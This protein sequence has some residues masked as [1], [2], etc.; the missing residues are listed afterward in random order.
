MLM[1]GFVQQVA[2]RKTKIG[3]M[4]DLVVNGDSYGH[5][6]YA[7]RGIS[8]GDYVEFVTEMNGNF[9]NIARGT[10]KKIDPPA[11]A[12]AAAPAVQNTSPSAAANAPARTYVANSFDDRQVVIS[13]QA[14]LNT[15]IAF[16]EVA[17]KTGAIALPEAKGKGLAILDRAVFEYAAKFH[18]FSTG[19]EVEIPEAEDPKAGAKRGKA[20]AAAT[21]NPDDAE[22]Q[23]DEIPF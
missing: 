23:D 6:K 4:F 9:R 14:A 22:W 11:G 18:K 7:P 10:L 3:D 15:A 13:K 21:P 2:T 19:V 12:A 1:Q 8:A 5:G 20:A 17:T 16:V